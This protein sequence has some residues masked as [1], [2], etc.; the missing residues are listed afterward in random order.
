MSNYYS[1]DINNA[2]N[3]IYAS[4]NTISERFNNS[5]TLNNQYMEQIQQIQNKLNIITQNEQNN[6]IQQQTANQS[7]N[8]TSNVEPDF[9]EYFEPSQDYKEQTKFPDIPS[10]PVTQ[11]YY[12]QQPQNQVS[13]LNNNVQPLV[14]DN[15]LQ[16]TY[17]EQ[18]N[19]LNNIV[20]P[21]IQPN[22]IQPYYP[23]EGKYPNME[24]IDGGYSRKK[25]SKKKR[26]S[27]KQK[28]VKRRTTKKRA[29]KNS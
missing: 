9:Q 5:V 29:R 3:E 15:P 28:T 23:Q 19:L 22:Q 10:P 26:R 2:L 21:N 25:S 27:F 13:L 8:V 18:L 4:I 16:I 14:Q 1:D 20:Q 17:P 7:N 12:Q 24:T 11:P 6:S